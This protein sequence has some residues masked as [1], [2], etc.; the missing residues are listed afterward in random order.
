M[1]GGIE[2]TDAV[3]DIACEWISGQSDKMFNVNPKHLARLKRQTNKIASIYLKN[4]NPMSTWWLL[5]GL[6]FILP[7]SQAIAF[8]F[9]KNRER[10][11]ELEKIPENKI[12]DIELLI[13]EKKPGRPSKEEIE[14]KEA[15]ERYKRKK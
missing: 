14:L 11:Q 10:K 3:K 2:L 9:F 8:R 12:K 1:E 15:Y 13:N 6:C 4:P 7:V 5:V